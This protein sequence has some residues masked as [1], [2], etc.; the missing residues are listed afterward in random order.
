MDMINILGYQLSYLEMS[1]TIVTLAC[2]M[3]AAHGKIITFLLGI[4]S[5]IL[6]AIFFYRTRLY[7]SMALQAVFFAFNVYGY[8][9]WA[10]PDESNKNAN[11]Q[12]KI[13]YYNK[14]KYIVIALI[15]VLG[16]ILWGVFMNNPPAFLSREFNEAQYPYIDA[17]ILVASIVAQYMMAKKKIENW[18]IW[19]FIDIIATILYLISGAV[20]TSILYGILIFNAIYGFYQW[21]KMYANNE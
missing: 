12:L 4:I 7:S 3:L 9:Q 19:I 16:T 18:I 15:I 6:Y 17:F 20:F 11:N 10:H 14:N 2:I 1:A 21:R 13:S 5:T 8:I